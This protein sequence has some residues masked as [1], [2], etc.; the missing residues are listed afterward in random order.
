[1]HPIAVIISQLVL[2]LIC[3]MYPEPGDQFPTDVVRVQ[4]IISYSL[5]M[6]GQIE[7]IFGFEVVEHRINLASFN[8]LYGCYHQVA[9]VSSVCFQICCLLNLDRD[10]MQVKLRL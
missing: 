7:S 9:C 8:T 10:S 1:M 4:F 2:Y 3:S 6:S 5:T